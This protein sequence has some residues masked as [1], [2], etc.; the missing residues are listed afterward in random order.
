[1]VLVK[2]APARLRLVDGDEVVYVRRTPAGSGDPVICSRWDPGA[3]EPR[4]ASQERIGVDGAWDST[5]YTGARTLVLELVVFGGKDEAGNDRSAYWW[6]ERLAAFTHPSRRPYLYATRDNDD[7]STGRRAQESPPGPV[8]WRLALRGSPLSVSYERRTAALLEMTLTFVAPDGYFESPLDDRVGPPAGASAA[9][10]LILPTP[11]P[12]GFGGST[13]PGLRVPV[14]G[15][16]PVAPTLYFWGPVTDPWVRTST[17]AQFKFTGLSLGSGQ[18]VQVDMEYGHVRLAGSAT[19]S[20]Y[21]RVDW[22]V[23]SFWRLNPGVTEIFYLTKGGS[24]NVQWRNRRFT[25]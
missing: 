5:G 11:L 9:K 16:A 2:P 25:I 7:Y 19:A 1:M 12:W 13:S 6:A 14:E 24:V 22:T 3:P 4:V 23:S 8:E 18:F 17:G 21:H 15:S 20:V 10:G